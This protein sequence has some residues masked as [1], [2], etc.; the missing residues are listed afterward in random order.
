[1]REK[2]IPAERPTEEQAVPLQPVGN[3]RS[4]EQPAER[5]PIR[6]GGGAAHG[7]PRGAAGGEAAGPGETP[8][9]DTALGQRLNDKP[10]FPNPCW[11]ST[12]KAVSSGKPT[13]DLVERDGTLREGQ[14]VEQGQ[15][16]SVWSLKS[17]LQQP[18]PLPLFTEGSHRT[19]HRMALVGWDLKD[20]LVPAY[21][22]W[23]GLPTTR[24]QLGQIGSQCKL[25]MNIFMGKASV[26]FL[27]KLSTSIPWVKIFSISYNANL[28]SFSLLK[29]KLFDLQT[30]QTQLLWTFCMR[31]MLQPPDHPHG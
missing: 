4:T 31:K 11:N 8:P 5:R 1:M 23:A 25:A 21:L 2:H 14:H 16:V 7:Y 10:C 28:L 3:V 30:E 24:S 20:N 18:F 15:N 22:L 9:T 17:S 26:T 19:I 6:P 13:Q 27:G 12:W 29:E